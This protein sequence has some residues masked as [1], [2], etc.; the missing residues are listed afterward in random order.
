M[1]VVTS[2]IV[3]LGFIVLSA[4]ERGDAPAADTDA[5]VP[6]PP[7]ELADGAALFGGHCAACHGEGARGTGRGPPLVHR[8][9]EPSHHGDASFQLAASRGVRAHHW[10]FGDMPAVAGITEPEVARIIAYVRWLQR[11]AGIN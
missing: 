5:P 2:V 4:C 7:A 1:R 8:I 3:I 9:Y 6:A 10:G 11:D